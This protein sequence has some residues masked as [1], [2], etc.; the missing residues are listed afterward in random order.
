MYDR[1]TGLAGSVTHVVMLSEIST[2]AVIRQVRISDQV[3]DYVV[4]YIRDSQLVPG[5]DLP[6]ENELARILGVSRP[7]V[8]EA[9]NALVGRGLISVASGKAPKVLSLSGEPFSSLVSHGLA[10]GQISI[11]QVLDVRRSLEESGVM[12]AAR[13]RTVVDIVKLQSIM[14]ELSKV[15]CDIEAFSQIDM[16]FHRVLADATQNPLLSAITAG[17]ADV[18]LESSRTGLRHVSE[19]D[20]WRRIVTAHRNIADAVI[21][22]NPDDARNHMIAHFDAALSRLKQ[23][24]ATDQEGK[25]SPIIDHGI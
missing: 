20:E 8:R 13:H 2:S 5:D 10:T 7:A 9:T 18:A 22:G 12:L 11:L 25:L 21:A 3:A 16:S 15:D 14:Q 17:I 1:L 24:Q 4:R 23:C 6:S 19:A